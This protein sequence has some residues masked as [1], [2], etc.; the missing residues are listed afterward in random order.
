MT[1]HR[2]RLLFALIGLTSTGC[3]D[4]A[5]PRLLLT[6]TFTDEVIVVD[7]SDGR[8]VNRVA[9][10]PRR[11]APDEPSGVAVA[12]D[13]EHWLAVTSAEEATAQRFDRRGRPDGPALSLGLRAA[14]RPGMDPA[15][16]RVV[17]PEYWLG[18][19]TPGR[20]ARLD[21]ADGTVTLL[22]PLC[23]GPHQASF[24]PDGRW[25]AIP[26]ALDDQVLLLDAD[27]LTVRHRVFLP[28]LPG[29]EVVA[30]GGVPVVRPMNVA[31]SPDSDRVWVTLLR[32]SA[33]AAID[34]AGREVGR[35]P[36]PDGPAG[37]AVT[38]DGRRLVVPARNDFLVAVLDTES[39]ETL[40]RLVVADDPNPHGVVLSPDGAVAFVTHEGTARSAGGVTAIRLS[41]GVVLW[42]TEGGAFTLDIAW[43]P[44]RLR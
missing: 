25:V 44:F 16:A 40:D 21:L 6:S 5:G 43:Q 20:A 35:A 7:P 12:P 9:V 13:G 8:I 42:R 24:S 15:G 30:T 29:G 14:G 28:A 39:L 23:S 1:P 27:D 41:D 36:V 3:A 17:I 2:L 18:D 11:T 31:W 19:A 10:D 32:Q 38:P 4:D 26:C 37:I 33:V 34:T 22:P